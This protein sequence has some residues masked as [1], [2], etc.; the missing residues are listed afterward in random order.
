MNTDSPISRAAFL[1]ERAEVLGF[2]DC[3]VARAGFLEAEAPLFEKWLKMGYQADMNWLAQHFDLRMDP[4]LLVPGARS[5]VCL[6]FS[7]T[8]KKSMNPDGPRIARYAYGRDYHRVLRKKLK[9]LL[10]ELR[11]RFGE[12]E[13]RGFVDSAPVHERAWARRSG[14]GW[15]GKNS[16]LLSRSGGSYFFLAVLVTELEFA[17]DPPVTDHC[18]SCTRCI[19]ACPTQA[20]VADGVI[21]SNRCIS[22]HTIELEAA[23]PPEFRK[24]LNGWVFGCD[25]C[26]EVC[27]WNRFALEHDEAEFEPPIELFSWGSSEWF[28]LQKDVFERVFSQSPLKRAGYEKIAQTL[29]LIRAENQSESSETSST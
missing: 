6:S 28:E 18:G 23:V 13:G 24:D 21:D 9:Q 11:G 27:P 17:P 12:F 2:L 22:Y 25:I 3:R 8:P 16:L 4:R 19:E 10:S 29:S 15:I 14:L 20:I 1:K 26:Q 5:V 7:Y